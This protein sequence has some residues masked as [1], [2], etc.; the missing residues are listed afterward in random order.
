MLHI[1]WWCGLVQ[2]G[3]LHLPYP[4]VVYVNWVDVFVLLS[5]VVEVRESAVGDNDDG[6]CCFTS[7]GLDP[8]L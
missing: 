4:T 5:F 2:L 7:D 6:S 3:D 8:S 1:S